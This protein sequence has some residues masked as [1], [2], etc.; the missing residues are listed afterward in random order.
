MVYS[1]NQLMALSQAFC[2][3]T[4]TSPRELGLSVCA[5]ANLIKRI[6]AGD[7]HHA[8]TLSMWLDANWPANVPWPK[9]IKRGN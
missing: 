2:L 7:L 9:D 5:N 4:G 1:L 6:S 3:G 8:P